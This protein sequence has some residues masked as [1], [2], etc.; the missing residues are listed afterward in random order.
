MTSHDPSRRLLIGAALLPVLGAC[1]SPPPKIFTLTARPSD[2]TSRLA[3]TVIVPS[4]RTSHLAATVM[5]KSIEIAKYLDRPQFVRRSSTYELTV[6]EFERWGEGMRDMVTRVLIED[7]AQRLPD[8]QV[9]AASGSLTMRADVTVEVDIS[10][11]DPDQDNTVILAAR[12]VAQ[13]DTRGARSR[14]ER[15]EV[16]VPSSEMIAL[17][18]AMSDALAELSDRI[19]V[20]IAGA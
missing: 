3:A 9:F 17:V 4:A 19:V 15:I 10:R 13:R 11:F 20:G 1:V 2:Q 5:V 12:W 14:S 18:S 16:K 6:S 7:L 8:S